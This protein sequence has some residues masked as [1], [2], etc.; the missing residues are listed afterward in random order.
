[1]ADFTAHRKGRSRSRRSRRRLPPSD[2]DARHGRSPTS[3]LSSLPPEA[4][5]KRS[6]QLQRRRRRERRLNSRPSRANEGG[7]CGPS[8]RL[9]FARE[10]DA[11]LQLELDADELASGTHSSGTEP[12]DDGGGRTVTIVAAS[13]TTK[14]TPGRGATTTADTAA[15]PARTRTKTAYHRRR[16]ASTLSLIRSSEQGARRRH[17]PL[18]FAGPDDE[19]RSRQRTGDE[20]KVS[21]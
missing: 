7:F 8:R 14:T 12:Y 16:T 2:D 10:Q 1:L 17:P 4:D 6:H 15:P 5:C 13:T 11:P 18:P 19:D 20:E 9:Q 21:R 3:S